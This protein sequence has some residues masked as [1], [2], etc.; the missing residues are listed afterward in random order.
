METCRRQLKETGQQSEDIL[1]ERDGQSLQILEG[2]V[3]NMEEELYLECTDSLE[4][5]FTGI[6]DAY[7]RRR[8]YSTLHLCLGEEENPRLFAVY[9]KCQVDEGKA[10]K[11]ARTIG[12]R[13]GTETYLAI[14]R[15]LASREADKAEAVYKTVVTGL[16]MRDGRQVMGNLADPYVHR[17]FELARFTANEVHFHIE[18]IRFRELENGI[19]YAPIG[20]KNNVLTFVVPHFA[21]RL[22]LENFVIHDQV[23]NLF[24]MHPAGK[25]W[26]L[27]SGGE[28][29]IEFDHAF[30]EGEKR[31][32]ELF[33]SFF[34]SI[35][36]KERR[37]ATLQRNMLPIRYRKYMTEFEKRG[38][39]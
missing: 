22:P 16:K 31:Y 21:D 11:V 10:A 9:E 25:D 23:R 37:N 36:I 14:C 26:Y 38:I 33:T 34:H 39:K 5:V 12:N 27:I 19:L 35:A 20:P 2:M 18:F 32:S 17:V 3:M 30:S 6:Y 8:P 29:K 1:H 24:A 15:A 13:L 7:L 4:G 28:E